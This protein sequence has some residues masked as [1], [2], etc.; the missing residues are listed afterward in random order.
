MGKYGTTATRDAGGQ[1]QGGKKDEAGNQ[2]QEDK[3][4][5]GNKEDRSQDSR[6]GS[7]KNDRE[8]AGS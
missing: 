7:A 4:R 5:S 8:G 2:R 3:G 1:E 6:D